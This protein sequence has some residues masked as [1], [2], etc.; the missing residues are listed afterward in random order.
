MFV[1]GTALPLTLRRFTDDTRLIGLLTSVGLW[2]GIILG[3]LVNYI[4]DRLWSRFGRRRPFL[5]IAGCG[6]MIAMVLIPFAPTLGILIQLIVVSS[7]LGDVGS[8]QEPLWLEVIPPPQRGR[9]IA[10]RI[11]M[12]NMASMLFFQVMFAQFD[13]KYYIDATALWP[14]FILTGEQM[15]YL[16]AAALNIVNLCMLAFVVREVKPPGVHLISLKEIQFSKLLRFV[17]TNFAQPRWW[18]WVL[19]LATIPLILPMPASPVAQFGWRPWIYIPIHGTDFML[20]LFFMPILLIYRL[21]RKYIGDGE[22]SA[23]SYI[24]FFPYA[25]MAKMLRDVFCEKR[26]WWI[27]MYYC[28][29]TFIGPS[30]GAFNTLLL[31]EQFQYSKPNI[32]LT[33]VPT[34]VLANFLVTPVMGWFADK[35][36]RLN[37]WYMLII[38][39]V[40][41]YG[42]YFTYRTFAVMDPMDLPPWPAMMVLCLLGTVAGGATILMCFQILRNLAPNANPRLWAWV[43]GTV[44]TVALALVTLLC[45]KVFSSNGVPSMSLW[46]LIMCISSGTGCLGIISGPLLY[47][48]MP[49]DKIGTLSSGFGMIN[50][51]L[52]AT[53][54]VAVGSWIYYYSKWFSDGT[55]KDYSSAYV[56]QLILSVVT[57]TFVGLFLYQAMRGR[58]PEYGRLGLNSTEIDEATRRTSEGK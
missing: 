14:A 54:Q 29:G 56:L 31:V 6:T 40:A 17:K 5:L 11:L 50:T 25:F 28:S 13:E 38:S 27:Y 12:V 42:T 19:L 3:P 37:L 39:S 55:T 43:L 49:R 2:F 35:L 47:E 53:M 22:K 36:P 34:M 32:A 57:F 4:S 41:G 18:D 45:I 9:A 52:S 44:N 24:I 15:C 48:Y 16:L 7:I 51:A 21:F 8:T 1:S 46:F 23:W 26:W 10:I 30:L 33:G 58:I 20:V